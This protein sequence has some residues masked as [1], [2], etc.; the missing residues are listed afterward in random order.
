MNIL[1]FDIEEWFHLLDY[2]ATRDETEWDRYEVRIYENVERILNL[3]EE[4]N[5]QATF[6]IIGW[7]AKKYPDLIKKIA[8]RY[9][10]GSHTMTHHLV[11]QQTPQEFRTDVETSVKM[12]EDLTG[13]KMTTFRAPGF[14]IHE[15]ETWA[16]DILAE[17]G[18]ETDCSIFPAS[19]A[20]GG[21]PSYGAPVPGLL[22][23]GETIMREFPISMKTILG[24]ELIFS[25]GGYF[26]FFP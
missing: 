9:E 25:G 8:E 17:L 3:L 26:R 7:V 21:V 19:H 16:F 24:R 22:K 15:T 6:F 2:D 1:T 4:T 5:S 23:H 20:H 12:L 11:W 18:I 14:S 13:K 10:I